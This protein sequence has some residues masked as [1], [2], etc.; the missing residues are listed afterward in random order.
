M[1]NVL[2]LAAILLISAGSVACGETEDEMSDIDFS[3]IENLYAQPLSVIQK[4]VQGK[5]KVYQISSDGIMYNAQYP[6]NMFMEF[7]NDHYIVDNDDESQSVSYFTWKK[8]PIEN[9]IDPL[10]GYK[11][12][13][14]WEGDVI[15]NWYFERIKNDTLVMGAQRAPVWLNVI[16]VK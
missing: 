5:W 6:G 8:L 10:Y 7:K 2:K 12:Y 16:R 4:A 1:K 14:M 3:N 15:C 13:V 9:W 11:T